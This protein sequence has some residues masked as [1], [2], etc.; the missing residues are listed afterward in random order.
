[1][2]SLSCGGMAVERAGS[3]P[4]KVVQPNV[5]RGLDS[6]LR[7]NDGKEVVVDVS[8]GWDSFDRESVHC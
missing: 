6:R 8:R 3:V 4:L 1:M 7:G 2:L 5:N